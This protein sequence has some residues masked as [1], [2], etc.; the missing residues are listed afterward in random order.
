AGRVAGFSEASVQDVTGAALV[1][2]LGKAAVPNGILDRP[3]PLSA[4]EWE[5]M[6]LHPYYSERILSY[7]PPLRT[8]AQ[9]A[10]AHHERLDGSGYDRGAAGAAVA[11]TARVLAVA[12]AYEAMGRNRAYR[13]ALGEKARQAELKQEAGAGRLDVKAVEA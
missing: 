12:D 9:I 3:G 2:D 10:G 6:R 5:R 1:H 7:S 8:L 13:P 11:G 4:A